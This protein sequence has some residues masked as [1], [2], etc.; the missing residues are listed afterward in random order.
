MYETANG[1]NSPKILMLS[2][3]FP[4]RIIGGL[5]T[6][7]YYLSRA[8]SR[9][10]ANV[11]VVTCDFPNV[12]YQETV[13]GVKIFRVNSSS[14][15][16][17]D[18]LL[19]IYYMNSQMIE[20]GSKIL[21]EN[22]FDLIHAHD[23]MVA[24][25][26]LKLKEQYDFPLVATIHA[27]EIGRGRGTLYHNYQK[28]I[29]D[30]EQLLTTH[31]E[32]VICCSNYMS[33]HIQENFGISTTK[34]D[35]IPNAVDI[36]RFHQ[37]SNNDYQVMTSLHQRYNIPLSG[38]KVI[39]YVG[40]LVQEKELHVLTEAFEKLLRENVNNYNNNLSLVIV[41]EGPIK[42][43]LMAD[44]CRRGLQKHIHFLGFVEE[45]TLLALYKLSDI[46]VIPSLYEPFGLVALEAMASGVPV[47]V[48]DI[49]G[50]SEIIENGVTGLRFLPGD[51]NSLTAAIR[52]ILEVPSL[53]EHLKLNAYNYVV[54]RDD[55]DLVAKR[56]LQTYS[57]TMAK[58]ERIFAKASNKMRIPNA[59]DAFPDEN[60]L[61][62]QGLLRLLLTMGAT[63]DDSSKTAL[64]IASFLNASEASIKL[65]LG[66]LASQGYV[67]TTVMPTLTNPEV[68]PVEI[69][70]HLT[71]GG[72]ISACAD[73]S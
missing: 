23:W 49:G 39:L 71:G 70:Y 40:R 36:L 73:F 21:N 62:D 53:A 17:R 30:I 22:P 47:V 50:L 2:W 33:Y 34:I 19:W 27:T 24:R 10:G 55:W 46:F 54:K 48:S 32:R 20:R 65:I 29:H 37:I 16:E 25:A 1:H 42:E 38:E 61:T 63:K 7:V 44:V 64:E 43:S 12:P 41:G 57:K 28:T 3:E 13:D 11:Q 35:T 5:S 31:S 59:A 45:P 52:S 18:F 56:T 68:Y 66:R 8:L 69:R 72:I 26:A 51:S 9:M 67:S 6:H 15:S 4:P 58:Q 60:L 14:I